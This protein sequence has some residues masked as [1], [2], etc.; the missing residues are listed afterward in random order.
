VQDPV[1]LQYYQIGKKRVQG[2]EINAVGRISRHWAVSAGYT[3]MDTKVVD[4]QAV[5]SDG[6]SVLAYTPKSAFTAWTTYRLPFNLTLGGGARHAGK[7]HRGT[8]GAVGTPAYTESY[9]VFD[10]MA[11][12]PVNKH[13][14]LQLNVYNLFDEDYVASINKSGYRYIPGTPRSAMLTANFSF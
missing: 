11:S 10:A 3:V 1:D 4:G 5:T 9:W 2:I 14:Q 6:S 13:L 7:L 12:Y 8:D